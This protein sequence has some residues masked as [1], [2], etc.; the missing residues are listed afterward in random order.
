MNNAY[1]DAINCAL[2]VASQHVTDY[3]KEDIQF[4]VEICGLETTTHF[5]E[6]YR[7]KYGAD[8]T[9]QLNYIHALEEEGGHR[10]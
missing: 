3:N 5:Y 10:E 2:W 6:F 9:E 4:L 7:M 8:V 1:R